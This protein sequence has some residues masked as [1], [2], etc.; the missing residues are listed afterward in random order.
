MLSSPCL[1]CHTVRVRLNIL[2]AEPASHLM[3]AEPR[4]APWTK[5]S[6]SRSGY[7]PPPLTQRSDPRISVPPLSWRPCPIPLAR[8]S[9]QRRHLSSSPRIHTRPRL[10]GRSHR[11]LP[12][13]YSTAVQGDHQECL[14]RHMPSP[15]TATPPTTAPTSSAFSSHL[16]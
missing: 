14:C 11:G 4:T 15:Q 16:P 13:M 2:N 9:F 1:C 3:T 12:L 7:T 6:G 5:Q 8:A 10:P